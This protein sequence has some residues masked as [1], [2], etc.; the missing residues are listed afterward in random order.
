MNVGMVDTRVEAEH[1]SHPGK[2]EQGEVTCRMEGML[3][4]KVTHLSGMYMVKRNMPSLKGPE[5]T[6]STPCHSKEG[7]GTNLRVKTVL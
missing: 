3:H 5:W 2:A 6:K 4:T 1:R 7:G